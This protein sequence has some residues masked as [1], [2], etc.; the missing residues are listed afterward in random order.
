MA[1]ANKYIWNCFDEDDI[2][3][4]LNFYMYLNRRRLT[5]TYRAVV[6]CCSLLNNRLIAT[7]CSFANVSF[8]EWLSVFWF[9][10]YLKKIWVPDFLVSF[11]CRPRWFGFYEGRRSA[12]RHLHGGLHVNMHNPIWGE[13]TAT[14]LSNT[15][16]S[17]MSNFQWGRE[18][19]I[20]RYHTEWFVWYKDHK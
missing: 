2:R 4:V 17:I 18:Y 14:F 16:N 12:W 6:C 8:C 3:Y 15:W 11:I 19:M 7:W 10:Q 9:H 13:L 20:Y 1:C 5:E